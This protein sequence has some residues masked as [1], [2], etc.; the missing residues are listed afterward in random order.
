MA[1]TPTSASTRKIWTASEGFRSW[2]A[3]WVRRRECAPRCRRRWRIRIDLHRFIASKAT[4]KFRIAFARQ[5]TSLQ[6]FWYSRDR[7][8]C[9]PP[10]DYG[11]AALVSI[12]ALPAAK[13]DLAQRAGLS[14]EIAWTS[15]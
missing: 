12:A 11:P 13:R 4:A 15:V 10:L 1:V 14:K 5:T 7:Y 2:A 9:A 8:A 3:T 6:G